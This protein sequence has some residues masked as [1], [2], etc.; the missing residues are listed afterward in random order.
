MPKALA[1]ARPWAAARPITRPMLR[2]GAWY[3]VVGEE[4]ADTLVLE[5]QHRDVMVPRR[6]LELRRRRPGKFTVVYRTAR[7]PNP[8]RGADHDLGRTYVVC[9]AS[10][11]RLPLTGRPP[12]M[13]CPRCSYWGKIAWG[14][15]G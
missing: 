11:H 9:P 1:W 12:T 10:G 15:T 2:N 3:P 8:A 7:D 13:E 4:T 14:E 5:V 6:L